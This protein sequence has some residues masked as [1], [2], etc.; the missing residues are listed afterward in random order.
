MKKKKTIKNVGA[1]K[2]SGSMNASQGVDMIK[3]IQSNQAMLAAAQTQRLSTAQLAG[4]AG[5]HYLNSDSNHVRNGS[6]QYASMG[7]TQK[8]FYPKQ[9]AARLSSNTA[10]TSASQAAFLTKNGTMTHSVKK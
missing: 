10:N 9:S 3:Q 2:K 4:L 6:Q 7:A 1:M 5:G 8:D